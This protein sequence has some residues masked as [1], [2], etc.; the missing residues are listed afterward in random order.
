M[1]KRSRNKQAARERIARLRAEQARL[2]RRR[3]RVTSG[4]AAAVMIAVATAIVLAVTVGGSGAAAGLP[5]RPSLAPLS[6]LGA[7]QPAP[8]PGTTGSE[9]VPVPAPA[10][11]AALAPGSPL[12]H[13][14]LGTNLCFGSPFGSGDVDAAFARADRC[15]D[16]TVRTSRHTGPL[17][18]E[19]AAH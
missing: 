13:D 10:P 8:A 15:V 9:G 6:T 2:R 11:L 19:G 5:S 12:V 7:L 4:V 17:M 16:V 1:A 14:E 18:A 3:I